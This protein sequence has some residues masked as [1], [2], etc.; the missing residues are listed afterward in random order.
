M[1]VFE[2]NKEQTKISWLIAGAVGFVISARMLEVGVTI[3]TSWQTI[4]FRA[5]L[6]ETQPLSSFMGSRWQEFSKNADG[7]SF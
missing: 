4:L 6:T 3:S 1:S 2:N 5:S 7:L